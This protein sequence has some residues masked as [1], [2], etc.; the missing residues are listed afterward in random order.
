M[1]MP[2]EMYLKRTLYVDVKCNFVSWF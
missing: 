2:D 1:I